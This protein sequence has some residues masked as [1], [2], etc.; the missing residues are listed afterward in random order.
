[1]VLFLVAAAFLFTS[2]CGVLGYPMPLE[3]CGWAG[4][5][6]LSRPV[7]HLSPIY[8]PRMLHRR[9]VCDD[10]DQLVVIPLV[11]TMGS[12]SFGLV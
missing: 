3:V 2:L 4:M 11:T 5:E 6:S 10:H 7:P 8:V 1:M 12:I 9:N